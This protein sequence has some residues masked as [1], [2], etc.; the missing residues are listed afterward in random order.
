MYF[1]DFD[2]EDMAITGALAEEL[3]NEKKRRSDY[4]QELFDLDKENEE[5]E[6]DF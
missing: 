5:L 4:D 3:S 2:W 1:D 6:N